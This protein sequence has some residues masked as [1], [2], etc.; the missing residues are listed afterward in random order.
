VNHSLSVNNAHTLIVA[1]LTNVKFTICTHTDHRHSL[2]N[3]PE[4]YYSEEFL[5]KI[6]EIYG[7]I[8][9]NLIITID[10]WEHA[11]KACV[12]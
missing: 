1:A 8:S 9:D 11:H 7:K 3:F 12:L 6:L 5:Q 10:Q 4:I 2:V